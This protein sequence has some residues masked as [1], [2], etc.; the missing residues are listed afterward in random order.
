MFKILM[1][2]LNKVSGA[3]M[4]V[5][6]RMAYWY[7]HARNQSSAILTASITTTSDSDELVFVLLDAGLR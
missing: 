1:K 2:T 3:D 4:V 6:H 5:P 7:N